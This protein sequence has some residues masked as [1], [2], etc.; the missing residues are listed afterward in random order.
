MVSW[1]IETSRN[2]RASNRD[3]MI[4]DMDSRS[5]HRDRTLVRYSRVSVRDRII[6]DMVNLVILV[7]T[8]TT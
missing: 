2:S 6:L 5:S 3:R 4:L 1:C 7:R 8:W